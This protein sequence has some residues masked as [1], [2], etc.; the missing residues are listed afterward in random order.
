MCIYHILYNYFSFGNI[1]ESGSFI[2]LTKN[3]Q[4]LNYLKLK[5]IPLLKFSKRKKE[6]SVKI[7]SNDPK[8]N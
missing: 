7:L 3:L 5:R 2:R 8:L 6:K 4:M 1:S